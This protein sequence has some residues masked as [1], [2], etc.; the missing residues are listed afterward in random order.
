[1][2]ETKSNQILW[3][4]TSEEVASTVE[5]ADPW[6]QA[7]DFPNVTSALQKAVENGKGYLRTE[8]FAAAKP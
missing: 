2:L 4:V 6:D 5:V 7:P 1:M 8:Y 3:Q